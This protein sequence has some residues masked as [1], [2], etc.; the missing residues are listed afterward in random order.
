MLHEGRLLNGTAGLWEALR[1][2][3]DADHSSVSGRLAPRLDRFQPMSVRGL[4]PAPGAAM[5]LSAL[6]IALIVD[7]AGVSPVSKAPRHGS[8]W[9]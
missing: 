1:G 3:P 9:P 4:T 8:V 6:P 5:A 2:G 7:A